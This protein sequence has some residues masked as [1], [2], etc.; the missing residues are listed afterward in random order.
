MTE[1]DW[2]ASV[3]NIESFFDADVAVRDERYM[4]SDTPARRIWSKEAESILKSVIL[5]AASLELPSQGVRREST[6]GRFSGKGAVSLVHND[7]P[8]MQ[9]RASRSSTA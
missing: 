1:E 2:L 7:L 8:R 6:L 9:S 5:G 4:S 3:E